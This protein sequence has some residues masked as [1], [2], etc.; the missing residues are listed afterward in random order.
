VEVGGAVTVTDE[1]ELE[2]A[3]DRLLA[4]PDLRARTGAAARELVR[5]QQG[6]TDRTL[7]LLDALTAPPPFRRAAA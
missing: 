3:L 2:A 5:R 6:A 4:D 1:T 7:D